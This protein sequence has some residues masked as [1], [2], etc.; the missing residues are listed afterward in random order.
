[1]LRLESRFTLG[2]LL[3]VVLI[4][5]M[6]IAWWLDHARLKRELI[7]TQT[8]LT[9]KDLLAAELESDPDSRWIPALLSRLKSASFPV[10]PSS[11]RRYAK[12]GI[13]TSFR[14]RWNS[15]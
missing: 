12:L 5:A 15:S 2:S 3:L 11:S 1:M 7:N 14:M 6:G 4:V 13:G 9:A 10:L 8:R